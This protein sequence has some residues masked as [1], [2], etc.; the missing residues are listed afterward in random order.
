ML[1]S[2]KIASGHKLLFHGAK[3]VIEGILSVRKGRK[4]ND[5]GQG[6]SQV[7]AMNRQ[8]RLF[9]VLKNHVS[10]FLILIYQ[11]LSAKSIVWIRNGC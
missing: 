8:Y 3:N 2:K 5:F 4:N 9:P 7:K 10:I 6:F 11:I 1:W